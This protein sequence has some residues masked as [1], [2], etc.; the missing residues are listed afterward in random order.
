VRI[1]VIGVGSPHGDDAVG[2]A[3]LEGLT[4][5]L[6]A[7]VELRRCEGPALDLLDALDGADAAIL[8]DATRSGRAPG[9]VHCPAPEGLR[10][11][12]ALSSHGIGVAQALALAHSL[13]RAPSRLALVGVEAGPLGGAELSP[14]ARRGAA[15]AARQVCALVAQ[16]CRDA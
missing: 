8:I 15:E 9:E 2:L 16:W 13:G 10:E 12:R 3:T 1:R 7:A 6:P 4:G 14:A 5:R 11:P